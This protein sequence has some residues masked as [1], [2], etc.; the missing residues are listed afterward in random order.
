[1][2]SALTARA[3]QRSS[4]DTVLSRSTEAHNQDKVSMGLHA[5]QNAAEIVT[6]T[7]Q[8][9]ATLLV[10]LSNAATLRDEDLLSSSGKELL[11]Q[12]RSISPIL[13]QDRRLDL[14][15]EKLTHAI[16]SF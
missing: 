15:L 1:T 10:A 13:Q 9:L 2:C 14:D 11:Q 16:L 3:I 6:L 12:I 5:A 8:V 4:P 7:Q